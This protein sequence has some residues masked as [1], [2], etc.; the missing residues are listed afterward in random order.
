MKYP[1]LSIEIPIE[2]QE[3]FAQLKS[4]NNP[5]G[6]KL[7][8]WQMHLAKTLHEFDIFCK[9]HKIEYSLS[10]GT[11]LGAVRHKG[12]IPWDDDMDI[13]MTRDNVEK[14]VQLCQGEGHILT[15]DL[16]IAFGIRPEIWK[17]PFAYIDIFILDNSPQNLIERNLKLWASQALYCIVKCRGRID[18]RKLKPVK[19]WYIFIPIAILAPKKIWKRLWRKVCMWKDDDN[20]CEYVQ[21][22]NYRVQLQGWR[23]K[24]SD[25]N[26]FVDVDF[27]GYRFPMFAGY[28]NL[29]RE[30]YGDYMQLPMKK[31]IHGMVDIVPIE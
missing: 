25:I 2:N 20:K 28:H 15:G 14:L 24:K 19:P 12:F 4:E 13:W 29:L 3:L 27:E 11:M 16:G 6:S 23:I 22:Y 7:R 26:S 9:E 5:E 17:A 21:I 1:Y 10:D 31:H 8:K 30:Q 18:E